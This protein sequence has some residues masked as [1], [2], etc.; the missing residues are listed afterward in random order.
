MI[1]F[2][3]GLKII[4]Q[5]LWFSVLR[6]KLALCLI[7]LQVLLTSLAFVSMRMSGSRDH[8]LLQIIPQYIS[9]SSSSPPASSLP[10]EVILFTIKKI[11]EKL[12]FDKSF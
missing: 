3:D 4:N 8:S 2:S 5:F 11:V 1:R 6:T 7:L 12:L 10:L 9:K